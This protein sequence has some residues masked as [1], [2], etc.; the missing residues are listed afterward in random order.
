MMLTEQNIR[1]ALYYG[2]LAIAL[3][4]TSPLRAQELPD[5]ARFETDIQR[6]ETQDRLDPPPK[7]AI[8]LTGSSSIGRQRRLRR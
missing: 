3:S 1:T 4:I 7:G 5:P 2:L 6:F 8:V